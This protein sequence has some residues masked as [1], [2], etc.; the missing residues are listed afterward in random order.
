MKKMLV[1]LL[2]LLVG[3]LSACD[4]VGSFNDKD[5]DQ[6]PIDQIRREI[7]CDGFKDYIVVEGVCVPMGDLVSTQ[8]NI[9]GT[10]TRVNQM[11]SVDL[12]NNFVADL[13]GSTGL[14]VVSRDQ[15]EAG[16]PESEVELSGEENDDTENLIVKLNEDGFFEEVSFSDDNGLSVE[17][18]SNPL[19]LEVFGEFTVVIFEVD[20]GYNDPNQEFTQKLYDS[21]YAGG[22]YLVHNET[23]KLFATKEVEFTEHNYSYFEDHSR[24][25]NLTV[26]LNEPVIERYEKEVYDEFGMPVLDDDGNIVM[27]LIENPIL[28]SEGNPLIFTEGP[29]Q[30]EFLE[31]PLFDYYE[32]ERLDDDGNPVLDEEG[33]PIYDLVEEPILDEDG[34]QIVDVQEVPM[35]DEDGNFV[36]VQEFEVELFIE[37]Q[38]EIFVVEYSANITDNP[39]SQIAQ[40]FVDK[41]MSEYY[42]WNYYRVNDYRIENHSFA[43]NDSSIFFIEWTNGSDNTNNQIL[44]KLYFD[45]EFEEIVIED[46]LD[47][48]KAGFD[49]C[50]L[51]IDPQ[52]NNI[53]CKQWDSNLKFYSETNGLTTIPDSDTLQPISFPN[54]ELYF[55]DQMET[56]VEELGYNTTTLYT[57]DENGGLEEH[58]IELGEREEVCYGECNFGINVDLFDIDGEAYGEYNYATI[59]VP[60]GAAQI[61]SA[62]LQIQSI[63][64]FDSS[65]PECTDANG[66]WFD[67]QH[68]FL[69]ID[70][71]VVMMVHNSDM[72]EIGEEV[73]P[74]KEQ[75]LL[76]GTEVFEYQKEYSQI[77]KLCE[78]EIGCP[79]NLNLVDQTINTNGLWLWDS[80]LVSQ[81][82]N[83]IQEII[84]DE[85]SAAVY[86]YEKVVNGEF[87]EFETCS[88]WVQVY[89]FDELGNQISHH[90][91]TINYNLDE[92]MPLRI[93]YHITDDT[94]VVFSSETCTNQWGCSTWHQM[95]DDYSYDIYYEQGEM[96]YH[97]VT[98]AE[99]DMETVYTETLVNELCTDI[100]GCYSNQL[101]YQVVDNDGNVVYEFENSTHI[102]YGYKAPFKVTVNVNNVEIRYQKE[103]TEEDALCQQTE[104]DVHTQLILIDGENQI[105]LGWA[106][107]QVENG[108][109]LPFRVEVQASTYTGSIDEQVCMDAN[110]CLMA[111]DNYIIVDELGNEYQYEQEEWSNYLQVK[112][113]LGEAIPNNDHFE[114]TFLMTNE[115]Y[116]MRRIN[117]YDFIYNMHNVVV[118]DNNL[119]LIESQSWM[120]GD[121]NFILTFNEE[122]NRYSVKYTNMYAV[123]E[124]SEFNDGFIAINDD[125]TAIIEFTYNNDLST[126]DFYY[127]DVTNLTEGLQ[128]NGVNDLIVDYDGSIYFK[129]VDNFIQD[130]TGS[131]NELGEITIDTEVVEHVVVRVRPIN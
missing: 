131:I 85:N 89:I 42:N 66:C 125:E 114:V 45:S 5:P 31:T 126:E 37:E 17:I 71:N 39:L 47:I 56:Y 30:T 1:V 3:S 27:E 86:E 124:I 100:D 107:Y 127:F 59:T 2:V 129:G 103:G 70:G 61:Q 32:V 68:E 14:A 57:I 24:V 111:T 109:K 75:Y 52:N 130:I 40:K 84:L 105:E 8:I 78:N 13:S 44:K 79:N 46:F 15:Y 6:N 41:I 25:V 38:L 23:G 26:T 116:Y 72:F 106:Y 53:I 115:E 97:T 16:M 91:R 19:A 113:E 64:E 96:M 122:T 10:E 28:D 63:G 20:L 9:N 65:R 104:C 93:E 118:L 82:D 50:E 90:G 101:I 7:T 12:M 33:N 119:Y 74:F 55:F 112:F 81:G 60:N 80:V 67:T 108:E 18:T 51:I 62:D 73:P 87:C 11:N 98:F 29:I 121:D 99:T 35:V 94:D 4:M 36:F 49:E 88:Q 77:D 21:L 48:T 117:V 43:S 34:N 83:L 110:G 123:L 22:I 54:G 128:I 76:N 102:E 95:G 69:D 120:Q 92:Q 58:Y